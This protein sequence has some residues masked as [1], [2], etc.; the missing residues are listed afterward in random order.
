[1]RVH[2]SDRFS[3]MPRTATTP[4]DAI[5]KPVRGFSHIVQAREHGEACGMHIRED[6]PSSHAQ[7]V[8]SN[9]TREYRM[10]TMSYIEG[11]TDERACLACRSIG[12]GK[13]CHGDADVTP[14]HGGDTPGSCLT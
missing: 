9:A 11:V 5:L 4:M 10:D 1:M 8:E 6:D 14:A 2:Y 12:L 3:D 13:T 7:S